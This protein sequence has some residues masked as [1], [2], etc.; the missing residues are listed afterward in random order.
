MKLIF[1]KIPSETELKNFQPS[2]FIS[3]S[4]LIILLASN[5]KPS[6]LLDCFKFAH[7]MNGAKGVPCHYRFISPVDSDRVRRW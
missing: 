7:I 1:W 3:T 2:P 6:S 5:K 4:S